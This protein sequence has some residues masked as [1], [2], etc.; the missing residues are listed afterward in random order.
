LTYPWRKVPAD[1]MVQHSIPDRYRG[2]VFALYDMSF[3]LPR[4]IAAALAI[5]LIPHLSSATLVALIGLAYL[6]WA[7]VPPRWVRRPRWVDLRFYAGG[8]AEEVPRAMAI[9]GEEEPVESVA[10]WQEEVSS[11]GAALR[12]RRFHLR[13][14]DG[15][16]LDVVQ[17][18]GERRWR[19]AAELPTGPNRSTGQ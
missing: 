16:V 10:S 5:L 14:A 17:A 6:A 9:G 3:A 15:S 12:Q 11:G 19:I 13:T 18:D 4:V 1:T 7:P 8:K 2:R